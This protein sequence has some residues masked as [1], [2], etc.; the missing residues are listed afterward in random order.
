MSNGKE[1]FRIGDKVMQMRNTEVA[2]NGDTGYIR[3]IQF[4]SSDDGDSQV[5]VIIEFNGDGIEHHLS[6]EQMRYVTLAY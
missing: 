4:K 2:K 1:T 5:E 6:R 3:D